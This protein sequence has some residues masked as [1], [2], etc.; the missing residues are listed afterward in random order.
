ISS[1]VS[2]SRTIRSTEATTRPYSRRN[3]SSTRA[4]VSPSAVR[5]WSVGSTD[6]MVLDTKSVPAAPPVARAT[7]SA[8][9]E[10]PRQTSQSPRF[11]RLHRPDGP[12]VDETALAER[13]F[14]GPLDRF[15][16][17]VAL[18]QV[19]AAEGFLR[20]GERAVHHLAM[21]GL[22]AYPAGLGVRPQALAV[23]HLA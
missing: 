16:P 23:D 4:R 18:D 9:D 3:A 14:L 15:F 19:E 7:A 12:H 10:P 22:E 5:P 11:A 13:D 20:L 6:R 21:P 1:A 8:D 2:T 17:R